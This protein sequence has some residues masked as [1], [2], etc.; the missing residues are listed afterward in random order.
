MVKLKENVKMGDKLKIKIAKRALTNVDIIRYVQKL[1][2][3]YF[4][5]VFMRDNLPKRIRQF[6][7][8][9]V[10]LDSIRNE[11]SHWTAYIK[12]GKTVVYFDSYG[13]LKPTLELMKYFNSNGKVSTFYTYDTKQKSNSSNCGQLAINFINNYIR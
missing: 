10:N 8:G 6:E 7:C 1:K 12:K 11:G 9:I 5:G 2:I 4:R 3:P 13:N